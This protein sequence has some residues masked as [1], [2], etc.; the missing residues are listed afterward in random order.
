MMLGICIVSLLHDYHVKEVK[1]HTLKLKHKDNIKKETFEVKKS[2]GTTI[3]I[4]FN[5]V[6]LFNSVS[7]RMK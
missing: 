1:F 7:K 5:T 3:E 6:F 4:L 2:D